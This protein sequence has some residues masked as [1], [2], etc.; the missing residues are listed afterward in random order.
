MVLF[1]ITE[2][3]LS[4]IR[5]TCVRGPASSR[6]WSILNLALDFGVD[7]SRR[8]LGVSL[9]NTADGEVEGCEAEAEYRAWRMGSVRGDEEKEG[10]VAPGRFKPAK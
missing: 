1:I 2:L 4:R 8:K 3:L 5:L 6:S 9:I 7:F 10:A